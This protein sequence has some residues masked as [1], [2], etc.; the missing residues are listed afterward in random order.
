MQGR[1]FVRTAETSMDIRATGDEQPDDLP[2]I[3]DDVAIC[4]EM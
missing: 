4:R 1:L 2:V 3:N